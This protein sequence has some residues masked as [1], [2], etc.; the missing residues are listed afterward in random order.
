MLKDITSLKLTG[1]N[2]STSTKLDL[3]DP[4]EGDKIKT[5]KGALLY[6]RN[7]TGKST[8][9]K[10]FRSLAGEIVPAITDAT[11]LD[12]HNR[13]INLAE[14]DK[15]RIFVFDEDYV[16][17]NVKLQPDHLETIVMLGKAAD[18]TEKI[19]QAEREYDAAKTDFEQHEI[20]FLEYGDSTNAKSP[21]HYIMLLA[22][23]L[24][25]D[26]NWAGRDKVINNRRQN[27]AVRD[28]TY[29]EFVDITPS[30]PRTELILDYD[31]KL[32][33]LEA[34]K[35]GSTTIDTVVPNTTSISNNYDDEVIKQ[36][37]V[38]RIE[39]PV[40]SEREEKLLELAQKGQ[41]SQLSEKLTVFRDTETV[42]CPYCYQ[43]VTPEYRKAL[44]ASLE[45][46]LSRAVKD[47][48]HILEAHIVDPV[49]LDLDPFEKLENYQTCI[50][51]VAK[52]NEIIQENN[53]NLQ[54][55]IDNPYEPIVSGTTNVSTITTQLETS[56]KELENERAEYNKAARQTG[57][58]IEDLKR[59]NSEIAHYDIKPLVNQLKKQ[60]EDF[61]EARETHHRFQSELKKA[62]DAVSKLEA[63]R[64][65]IRLA[66]DAIN[67]CFKYIFFADDRLKIEYHDGKYKLLSHGK[68][69]KP[70]EV[71]VG[72]RNI[73]GLS[74]FFTSIL[75]G[76]EEAK[77][78]SN[79]YLLVIDDP[80]SSYDLESKI[81]ILSFL[82]Y[83]LSLFLEGNANTKAFI[84]THD[85]MAF[86]DLHKIFEEIVEVCKK[87]NYPNKPKFHRFEMRDGCLTTFSYKSR[88]E[89]TEF[90]KIIHAYA[91]GQTTDH[92]MAIGNIMRQALEAFST[93]VY[94]KGIV[95][96]STDEEILELLQE[97]E[98]ISYYKNL[99]YRLVLHG[100]SHKEE[101]IKAMQDFRFFNLISDVEKQRTAR[102]VLCFIYLLNK[103]HLLA[104]LE[105][106]GNVTA[107]LD[108]W[109]QDIKTRAVVI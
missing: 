102:D 22:N 27:T 54:R 101:Q 37:L 23:A 88:Q 57:P 69:V 19:T 105:G 38:E 62:E 47:H 91:S 94:R 34:A 61:D 31:A 92:V 17:K 83:K 56:L 106:C 48:Q 15:K 90:L 75:E 81:G 68:S 28:D 13:P 58:L 104:H 65:S 64:K 45:K 29:K 73:I 77:A 78:Y 70:Y 108:S 1:A 59:I 26:D 9:A 72:E 14:E 95:D 10:A 40:L 18:L 82:K 67:A 103:K 98:F 53:I 96:V 36:L 80:V 3:F 6:G 39:K 21:K 5:I 12:V 97:D 107:E 71:S 99:M 33:E 35:S 42:N 89:Y 50:N 87:K 66:V 93:F 41:T 44:V 25:G 2:F 20:T 32:K 7:G 43:P 24:R 8:I 76:Q 86:Y 79:E 30:K 11:F 51:L 16:Y 84:M 100:E 4:H 55:K 85:L 49:M 52:L 74:Y 63:Q 60:Q 109:C 46:I